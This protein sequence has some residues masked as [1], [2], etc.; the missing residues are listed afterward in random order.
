MHSKIKILQTYRKPLP[1]PL[2]GIGC[3]MYPPM[4]GLNPIIKPP[5]MN[6]PLPRPFPLPLLVED[7]PG[8]LVRF[9][10][11]LRGKKKSLIADNMRQRY[12]VP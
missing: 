9:A 5:L 3:I 12:S 2:T 8:R 6:P 4:Y 11:T 1:R 7:N 10:E